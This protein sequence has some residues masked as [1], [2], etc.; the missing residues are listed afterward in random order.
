M[1]L[2]QKIIRISF[3][4]K[5]LKSVKRRFV[6]L[7]NYSVNKKSKKFQK[8]DDVDEAA[9]HKWS[10]KSLWPELDK[11]GSFFYHEKFFE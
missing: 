8:N 11:L 3:H 10:L 6:H 9:G 2:R 5:V 1:N 7:T 4:L